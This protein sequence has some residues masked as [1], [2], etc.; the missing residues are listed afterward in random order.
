MIHDSLDDTLAKDKNEAEQQYYKQLFVNKFGEDNIKVLPH[1]WQPKWITSTF[2]NPS[3]TIL[4]V[5]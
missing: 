2:I 1:Y 3:A 4:D 5:Y